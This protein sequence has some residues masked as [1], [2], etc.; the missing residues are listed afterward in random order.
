MH[1]ESFEGPFDLLLELVS[2]Q[3][4]DVAAISLSEVTDQYLATIEAMRDLDLD[5]ASDF[6]LVASTLLEIKS[7]A[8]LPAGERDGDDGEGDDEFEGMSAD[9]ARDILVARLIAYK[10]FKNIA[11]MLGARMESEGRMHPR[12]SGIEPAFLDL[13]PDYLAGVTLQGLSVIC[14]DLLARRDSFILEAEH[15]AAMPL[16]VEL[17]AESVHRLISTKRHMTFD[18]L[19]GDDATP[20]L[21]VVTFLAI[22]ELYKRN[23]VTL[24]QPETFGV[25][26]V[27]WRDVAEQPALTP[28]EDDGEV[29]VLSEMVSIGIEPS[30]ERS[31]ASAA[32]TVTSS[33]RQSTS[34]P[35]GGDVPADARPLSKR[36][37]SLLTGNPL[38]DA[39]FD[40][41]GE[42]SS[43]PRRPWRD[44][45]PQPT[46]D[47]SEDRES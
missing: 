14:A 37:A 34:K 22:L 38:S 43:K 45:Y 3:K 9:D 2:R 19:L 10:Q 13:M 46:P 5:V 30:A 23:L 11:G 44:R 29:A 32:A 21:I 1:I 17:H 28:D 18:E 4:V 6:L 20:E 24:E 15:I 12:H 16:S 25:L 8:L 31:P 35:L 36:T 33:A 40:A 42:A 7:A 27:D 41:D 39:A 26:H 47:V